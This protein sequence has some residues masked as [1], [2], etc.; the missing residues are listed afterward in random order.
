[1]VPSDDRNLLARIRGDDVADVL[2][3]LGPCT[4]ASR[5]QVEIVR[6]IDG[7]RV[8]FTCRKFRDRRWRRLFWTCDSA[9]R[10]PP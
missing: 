6:E 7:A 3:S 8:R 1:L 4:K 9:V 10:E 2:N 5:D